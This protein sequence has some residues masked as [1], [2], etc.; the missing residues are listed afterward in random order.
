MKEI[1]KN[2]NFK[3]LFTDLINDIDEVNEKIKKNHKTNSPE[4]M[5][6]YRWNYYKNKYNEYEKY[7]DDIKNYLKKLW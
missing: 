6:T 3:K 1:F 2:N 4:F 7:K 5:R